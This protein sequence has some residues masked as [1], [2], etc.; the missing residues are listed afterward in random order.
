MKCASPSRQS[1]SRFFVRYEATAIRTRLCIQPS[2]SS[3]RIPA[4]IHGTPVR[5][6]FQ[7]ASES[8][9]SFQRIPRKRSS[10][11]SVRLPGKLRITFR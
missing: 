6:S 8:G 5:P 1:I 7:A 10:Y 2:A 3:C 9:S 4:S 11:S